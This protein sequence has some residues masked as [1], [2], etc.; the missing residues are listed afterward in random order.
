MG[1]KKKKLDTM[2]G[3]VVSSD[4]AMIA[5][6]MSLTAAFKIAEFNKDLDALVAIA[7][8]W[9]T[10]SKILEDDSDTKTSFGFSGIAP[11]VKEPDSVEEDNE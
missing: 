6:A 2:A 4:T 7:D 5:S 9:M 1:K 10:I 11:K 3:S 8:R